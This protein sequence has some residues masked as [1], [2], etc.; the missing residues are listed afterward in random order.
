MVLVNPSF[1][2]TG[3]ANPALVEPLTKSGICFPGRVPM[4]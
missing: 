4:L 1:T 2:I 3:Q